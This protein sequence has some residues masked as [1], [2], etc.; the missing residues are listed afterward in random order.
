[1]PI[2][3]HGFQNMT[4]QPHPLQSF[5]VSARGPRYGTFTV[6][7]SEERYS[8]TPGVD[9]CAPSNNGMHIDNQHQKLLNIPDDSHL[10]GAEKAH[11]TLAHKSLSGHPGDRSSRS[12]TR[13]KDLCSL[14][15]EDSA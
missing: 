5:M 13:A 14:G 9:H 7:P 3:P 2:L 8:A 10:W 12:G 15:S 6:L 4:Q 11:K 1:M